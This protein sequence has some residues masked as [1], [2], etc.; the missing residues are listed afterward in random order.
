VNFDAMKLSVGIVV[1]VGAFLL[2]GCGSSS[3]NSAPT[4]TGTASPART[5]LAVY[6]IRNG[7]LG[8]VHRLVSRTPAVGSAALR[9]LLAGPA[10][11]ERAAGLTS[12]I[13]GGTRLL[14]LSIS[15]AVATVDFS[16]ELDSPGNRL[17]LRQR[18]AQ[19]VFTLTQFPS[20]H[21]VRFE[22]GGRPWRTLAALARPVGRPEFELL[23]PPIIVE[24]PAAG[25]IVH[26]PLAIQGTADAFEATFAV[27]IVDGAGRVLREQVVMASTGSGERG[28]FAAS[29]PFT[30]HTPQNGALLAFEYSAADGSITH[31]VR[32]PLRL[33]PGG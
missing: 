21:E 23:A 14:G 7:K 15:R 28:T 22:V 5:S 12:A 24:S 13:P 17:S 27:R 25:A 20:V 32:V 30:V 19:V 31:L 26:S 18:A 33:E 3:K 4:G 6:L 9:A 8:L 1:L 11:A 16:R 10:D 29:V 2:A